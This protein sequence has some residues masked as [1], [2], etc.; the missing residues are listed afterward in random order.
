MSDIT[1][2]EGQKPIWIITAP[3]ERWLRSF[4]A[5]QPPFDAMVF[6]AVVKQAKQLSDPVSL[7]F[8]ND[9][10]PQTMANAIERYG[11]YRP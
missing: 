9:T 5:L 4:S 2:A 6:H 1:I 3:A 7:E 10:Y 11:M 8:D